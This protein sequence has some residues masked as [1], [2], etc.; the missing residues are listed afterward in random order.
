MHL[1]FRP[2][3]ARTLHITKIS[4]GA[5]NKISS[6]FGVGIFRAF[7]SRIQNRAYIFRESFNDLAGNSIRDLLI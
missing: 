6:L 1:V 4:L 5:S 3:K 2:M 7:M